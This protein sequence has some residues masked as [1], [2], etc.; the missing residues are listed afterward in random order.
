M[1][2]QSINLCIPKLGTKIQLAQNWTFRLYHE[3]RNKTALKS[4]GAL[5][6]DD[7]SYFYNNKDKFE[8]VTLVAG[9][10][11]NVSRIYIRQGPGYEA[12]NS[13]T[14]TVKKKQGKT[15][16]GKMF[17]G[18]FWAKLPEVNKIVCYPMGDT[19]AL[20]EYFNSKGTFKSEDRFDV[21]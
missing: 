15:S 9:T 16:E 1:N 5:L 19:I 7:W 12:F 20:Q 2:F 4:I 17:S 3:S 10:V 18:R 8:T 14:F 6:K 21:L 11:L 13:V